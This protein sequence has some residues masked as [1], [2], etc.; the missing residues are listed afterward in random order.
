MP[1]MGMYVGANGYI[2]SQEV[3]RG[4]S[5]GF[6]IPSEAITSKFSET[7]T[8]PNLLKFLPPKYYHSW[9]QAP[10]YNGPM[11]TQLNQIETIAVFKIII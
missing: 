2:L 9:D 6:T 4:R 7:L 10:N 1:M 5:W 3:D 11:G 8:R